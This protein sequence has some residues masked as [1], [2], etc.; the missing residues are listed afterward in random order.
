[1]ADKS[2]TTKSFEARF[3][4]KAAKPQGPSTEGLGDKLRKLH[5]VGV[6]KEGDNF[7]LL[8]PKP[9][10]AIGPKG[11]LITGYRQGGRVVE[12]GGYLKVRMNVKPAKAGDKPR[13]EDI[14]HEVI[15]DAFNRAAKQAEKLIQKEREKGRQIPQSVMDL[16]NRYEA[17]GTHN[18]WKYDAE[19]GTFEAFPGRK[20]P[21]ARYEERAPALKMT[22][23]ERQE[24]GKGVHAGTKRLPLE[25]IAEAMRQAT[26]TSFVDKSFFV[27]HPELMRMRV[28]LVQT[29]DKD[30]IPCLKLQPSDEEVDKGVERLTGL[31]GP[32]HLGVAILIAHALPGGT[33]GI[34]KGMKFDRTPAKM[35]HHLAPVG[36][37]WLHIYDVS[38]NMPYVAKWEWDKPGEGLVWAYAR[39]GYQRKAGEDNEKVMVQ[40]ILEMHGDVKVATEIGLER[41][42]RAIGSQWERAGMLASRFA[43]AEDMFTG[44][45][46]WVI[47][48]GL[49][50]AS[51][52]RH[53]QLGKGGLGLSAYQIRYDPEAH[54]YVM[55]V[56]THNNRPV[57]LRYE[58]P[59]FISQ[60][61]AEDMIS[62]MKKVEDRRL[63]E[64]GG[65]RSLQ[66]YL[67]KMKGKVEGWLADNI[68]GLP[69]GATLDNFRVAGLASK[70]KAVAEDFAASPE[71]KGEV[72]W[73]DVK[74]EINKRLVGDLGLNEKNACQ[75]VPKSVW[76][77]VKAIL[78]AHKLVIKAFDVW[79]ATD[80]PVIT[81]FA[82]P[83]PPV[84]Y[85]DY[86]DEPTLLPDWLTIEECYE[87]EEE[88]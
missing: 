32:E 84:E 59:R 54:S 4:V 77:D 71:V 8:V 26:V 61:V 72:K 19:T 70:I 83:A 33:E 16:Y 49:M 52:A 17:P 9:V 86:S 25:A 55:N 42:W 12:Y 20:E 21:T 47:S 38:T 79:G 41:K 85:F 64:I 2:A 88:G 34:Q 23:A 18:I 62:W 65:P 6:M 11:G 81:V 44:L 27:P 1:M 48:N 78:R 63:Q 58:L 43:I 87:A 46:A 13:W 69:E 29:V 24:K 14:H 74:D 35:T 39:L 75:R 67:N 57:T 80:S 56:H 68:G 37:K 82:V 30:G 40:K 73:K 51:D 28:K 66:A 7:Y 53:M 60:R 10:I 45:R 3:I 76:H 5:G 22:P 50:V 15:I 36:D 31:I